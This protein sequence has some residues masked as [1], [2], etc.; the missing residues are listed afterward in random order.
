MSG[1]FCFDAR[2]TQR[3]EGIFRGVWSRALQFALCY[4]LA[5]IASVVVA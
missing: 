2:L 5:Q 3:G 1:G 4:G